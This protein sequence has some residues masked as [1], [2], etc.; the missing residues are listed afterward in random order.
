MPEDRKRRVS[1]L[2]NRYQRYP[3]GSCIG[4]G[5]E[6]HRLRATVVTTLAAAL[7]I[8]A[9]EVHGWLLAA[10]ALI[11]GTVAAIAMPSKKIPSA[12]RGYIHAMAAVG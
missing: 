11:T 4:E 10:L 8:L 7:P 3:D 12:K 6:V 9:G 5:G 2:F 1:T